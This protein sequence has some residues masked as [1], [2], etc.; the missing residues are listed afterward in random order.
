MFFLN[1]ATGRRTAFSLILHDISLEKLEDQHEL[2]S[3][4]EIIAIINRD[5][6]GDMQ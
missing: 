1:L 2:D 5:M 3:L 4:A 6:E